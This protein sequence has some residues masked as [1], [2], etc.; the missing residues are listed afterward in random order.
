MLVICKNKFGIVY[1]PNNLVKLM[2][3]V[4]PK[5]YFKI[6]F[7]WLDVGAGTGNFSRIIGLLNENLKQ[8]IPDNDKRYNHILDNMLF[9]MKF[10]SH[11]LKF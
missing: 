1:T 11:I 3:N 6:N 4:I 8:L 9:M 7:K 2:L 5:I 10:M